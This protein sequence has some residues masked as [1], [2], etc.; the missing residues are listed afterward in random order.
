MPLPDFT[1]HKTCHHGDT[2]YG[3]FTSTMIF[4]V[5]IHLLCDCFN[6]EV[7]NKYRFPQWRHLFNYNIYSDNL[8]RANWTLAKVKRRHKSVILCKFIAQRSLWTTTSQNS[9]EN[10][11]SIWGDKLVLNLCNSLISWCLTGIWKPF[12]FLH[13]VSIFIFSK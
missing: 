11:C 4:K 12:Y 2:V 10:S 8:N 9:L 6:E 7:T 1:I 13:V 5:C 3:H